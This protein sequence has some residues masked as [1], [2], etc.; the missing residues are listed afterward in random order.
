MENNR[1]G[2][3]I[4]IK[5]YLQINGKVLSFN[6]D[7]NF[8]NTLDALMLLEVSKIPES[9]LAMLTKENAENQSTN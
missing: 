2:V 1:C 5:K 4:L 9:T 3:P 6:V 7:K 8:N